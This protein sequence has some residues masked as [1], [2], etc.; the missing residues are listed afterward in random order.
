MAKS[1]DYRIG[2]LNSATITSN[3]T[4]VHPNNGARD[5]L[6]RSRKTPM[7]SAVDDDLVNALQDTLFGD[8]ALD[9]SQ[10]TFIAP[11]SDREYPP[12]MWSQWEDENAIINDKLAL[13]NLECVDDAAL[14]LTFE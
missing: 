3:K 2:R 10:E 4:L 7:P 14:N 12:V 9:D 8:N 11:E 1:L 6:H 5:I 13:V